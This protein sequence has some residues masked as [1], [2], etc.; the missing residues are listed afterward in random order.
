MSQIYSQSIALSNPTVFVALSRPNLLRFYSRPRNFIASRKSFSCTI[1]AAAIPVA[2][3]AKFSAS[4]NRNLFSRISPLRQDREVVQVLDQWLSEG[5]NVHPLELQRIIRDLR[6]RRRFSQALQVSEWIRRNC[7][8]TLSPGDYA[9]HL[10]LV[11]VVHGCEA[12]E[13]CFSNLGDQDKDE[14]TYGA[15]LYCYVR[16]G[17]LTKTLLHLQ[18]MKDIGYGSSTITYNNLMALYK[19]AGQLEKIPEILS[20]MKKNSLVP[21]NFS[22]RICI[23]SFGEK[24]DLSGMEK[25]LDEMESQTD[26]T[27]DWNTYSMVAYQFIKVNEKEKALAYMKKVEEKLDKDAIGY[28]HLISLYAHL[29][30]KNE[31]MRLWVLQKFMCKKQINRDYI[32]MLGSLVKL[33]EFETAEAVLKEW[34]SSCHTYDFRVPNTLLIGYC[35]KGLIDKSEAVLEDIIRR[36]KKP[37]PNSWSIIAAG[38]LDNSNP[39]KALECMKRALAAI[40]HNDRWKPKPGHATKLLQ[41]LG[42]EGDIQEVDAFVCQL[43]TVMPVDREMYHALIKASVRVGK[44]AGWILDQMQNDKIAVADETQKLLCSS[45]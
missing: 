15:L 25:L 1:S 39:K 8:Y 2:N 24:S 32:T 34:D 5:R 12:A 17:L 31:M 41:W 21:D 45:S 40:E 38:Y 9:V 29:G 30:N 6:S 20:E 18:R 28:N 4:R 42:D 27:I 37:T 14:K 26:I 36:G 44:D 22:Y 10:D 43:K 19:K 23:S 13:S 33:E 3:S 7:V 35:Q 11:G 16:E